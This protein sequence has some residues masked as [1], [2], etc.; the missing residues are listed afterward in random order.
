MAA[1][2]KPYQGIPQ[3]LQTLRQRGMQISNTA[4]AAR[5]LRRAGYYRLS[6]YWYPMR[7]STTQVDGAGV[8]QTIIQDNFRPGTTFELACE[9]YVFDKKLRLLVLDAIER[10]EVGLRV[11]IADLLG[12]RNPLAHLDPG[13][14][15][16]NFSRSKPGVLSKHAQWIKKFRINQDRSNEEF[17]ANFQSKY[18]G[19]EFPIWMAIEFWDFGNLSHFLP[20]LKMPDR[21]QIASTY[22]LR[23]EDILTGWFRS[24][25]SVRNTCAHH[26]R[27]WNRPLADN[28]PPPRIGDHPFLDH[29]VGDVRAQTRLYALVVALQ[30]MLKTHHPGSTWGERLKAHC[31]TFPKSPHIDLSQAGFPANWMKLPLWRSKNIFSGAL[32]FINK[33]TSQLRRLFD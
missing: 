29:L 12:Q 9:L 23:R 17:K 32:G 22:G 4:A 5:H 16:G 30:F 15:H 31:R 6:G 25:N 10:V 20:G 21:L 7:Q 18:P 26:S 13:E 24:L 2:P 11:Q 3:L 19:T 27:L 8:S 28:P 1:Y 33:K 14:L